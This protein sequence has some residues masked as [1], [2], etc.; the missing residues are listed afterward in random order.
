MVG[1]HVTTPK[2]LERYEATGGILPPVRFWQY[3]RSALQW[4]KRVGRSV[5]LEIVVNKAYPM[6]DHSP[7]GH[8]WWTPSMVRAWAIVNASEATTEEK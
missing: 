2:K 6:P 5:V 8:A 1:Y 4:A 7:R 3:Q